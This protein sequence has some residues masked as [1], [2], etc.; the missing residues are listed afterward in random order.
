MAEME[1]IEL[2]S[3]LKPTH[4]L[5]KQRWPP[6]PLHLQDCA[7]SR[8]RTCISQLISGDLPLHPQLHSGALGG[9]CTLTP[10][11]G[12]RILSPSCLHSITS[13]NWCRVRDSNPPCHYGPWLL[14]PG[15]LPNSSNAANRKWWP[16]SESHRHLPLFKR[17][18]RLHQLHGQG[19][20]WG[21]PELNRSL[22]IFSQALYQAELRPHEVAE[23]VR[24][25]L[26]GPVKDPS[27]FEAAA[28]TKI[29]SS[30][31]RIEKSGG[32]SG[33]L[34]D[35]VLAA[36]SLSGQALFLLPERAVKAPT[37]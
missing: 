31:R 3:R 1:R 24:I 7:G 34:R 29:A 14:R 33:A 5:S 18:L 37:P 15:C 22:L 19:N 36:R 35:P 20:W 11:T 16:W 13:A 8:T 28:T 9:I 25:E 26:T 30:P 12:P 17:A 4:L 10:L 21:L 32:L 2:S 23:M 27:V 6:R